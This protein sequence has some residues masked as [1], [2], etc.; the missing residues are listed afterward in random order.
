MYINIYFPAYIKLE[1]AYAVAYLLFTVRK[2]Y[3]EICL[4]IINYVHLHTYTCVY[5]FIKRI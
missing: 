1:S 4:E 2:D 5:V 3:Y